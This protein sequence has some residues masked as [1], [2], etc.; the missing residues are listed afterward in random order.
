MDLKSEKQQPNMAA[1][2]RYRPGQDKAPVVVASGKGEI[3]RQIIRL[4]EEAGVPTHPE[5]ALAQLLARLEL[6]TAIPEETYQLVA[7]ILA[8]IWSLDQAYVN[9]GK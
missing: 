6:G 3:A 2:L 7:A 8:Y 9:D 4:A 1:A 5:P